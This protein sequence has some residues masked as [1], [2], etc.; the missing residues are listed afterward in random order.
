[1][2]ILTIGLLWMIASLVTL[3][4]KICFRKFIIFSV[5]TPVDETRSKDPGIIHS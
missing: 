4:L 1:M 5:S 2:N 3:A